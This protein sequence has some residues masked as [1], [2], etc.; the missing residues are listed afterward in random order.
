MNGMAFKLWLILICSILLISCSP[1]PISNATDGVSS[2]SDWQPYIQV[3]NN[4]EMVLVPRGCFSMGS[5]KEEGGSPN[6]PVHELCFDEPFWIGK[7]EVTNAQFGTSGVSSGDDEPRDSVTWY[8]ALTYCEDRGARLPTEAE[9]EYAARGPDGWT[10]P[11]GNTFIGN[12]TVFGENAVDGSEPVGSRPEGASW[13][14]ALDMGGNLDEWT[15]SIGKPYPYDANDGREAP[16]DETKIITEKRVARGGDY[17]SGESEISLTIRWFKLPS[18]AH[19][20]LG[21]RC[22]RDYIAP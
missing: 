12:N 1:D 4:M 20:Y 3:L 11:W 18:D 9:W 5:E 19:S 8:E 17:K 16:G 21:F 10:Y 15:S 6:S 14:G 22:A 7:T 2:N 13:V